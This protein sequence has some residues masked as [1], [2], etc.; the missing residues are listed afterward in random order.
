MFVDVG[1]D[2]TGSVGLGLLK[3]PNHTLCRHLVHSGIL[4]VKVLVKICQHLVHLKIW[5]REILINLP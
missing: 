5:T 2:V 1:M 4:D 3:S